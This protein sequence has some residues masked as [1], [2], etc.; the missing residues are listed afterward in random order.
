MGKTLIL[1]CG[2]SAAGKDTVAMK[3]N[4]VLQAKSYPCHIMIS[5][6]TRPKRKGE[7]NGVHYHYL[8]SEQFLKRAAEGKYLEYTD[9]NGWYYGTSADEI[10]DGFNIAIFD[11]A[12]V[13]NIINSTLFDAVLPVLLETNTKERLIRSHDR[14]GKWSF[15]FF[16][17]LAVDYK[18]FAGFKR[19][20]HRNS[21]IEP[22][23][24][25]NTGGEQASI[26]AV[27]SILRRLQ[28]MGKIQ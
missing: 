28:L 13:R 25:H 23:I 22:L 10:A 24:I 8:S 17:R 3:L 11:P 4:R 12:G 21:I 9:F 7:N 2:K 19:W 26:K 27:N 1:L 6:T 15:E 18:D 14:E 20:L 5:D 16:R